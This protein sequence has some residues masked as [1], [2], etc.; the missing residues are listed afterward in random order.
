MT[1]SKLT[2]GTTYTIKV[3]FGESEPATTGG[4]DCSATADYIKLEVWDEAG[5]TLLAYKGNKASNYFADTDKLYLVLGAGA[6]S[7]TANA[8]F[9]DIKA[10]VG[11]TEY[12]I[13]SVTDAPASNLLAISTEDFKKEVNVNE[14]VE[15]S[16]NWNSTDSSVTVPTLTAE[17]N[18]IISASAANG[19]ITINGLAGGSTILTVTH[20]G[21]TALSYKIEVA[22]IDYAATTY[23]GLSLYPANEATSAFEDG[24]FM[25]GGFDEAPVLVSGG[26][27]KIYDSEGNL[28]DTIKF[29][30]ENISIW[31]GISYNVA[32]QLVR[33][34]NKA[35]YF[36]PHPGVLEAGKTYF[37]AIPKGSITGKIGGATFDGLTGD[38]AN[39]QWKFST[40]AA[41]TA[42]ANMIVNNSQSASTQDF[43]TIQGALK[44][45]GTSAGDYTIT[46]EPGVYREL[47]YFGGTANVT[48]KGNSTVSLTDGS[49]SG[50]VMVKFANGQ[51]LNGN[52]NG[53]ANRNLFSINGNANIVL[54]N[55]DF[56]NS[57][58]RGTYAGD[59]QAEVIGHN[60][61][62]KIAAYNCAFRSH[63]DTIRTT[64]KAWFYK[65][66]VEGDVDF[67]WMEV[68]GVVAL[69]EECVIHSVYDE[70]ASSHVTRITAPRMTKD[71]TVGKGL[72]VFNSTITDTEN[73]TTNLG[74]TP[75]TS[76]YY[77]QAAFIGNTI[78]TSGTFTADWEN[79]ATSETVALDAGKFIGWKQYNNKVNGTLVSNATNSTL[80]SDESFIAK[81]YSGRKT[82]LNR[83]LTVDGLL[84]AQDNSVWDISALESEFNA[85]ED[86]SK[87]LLDDE[88]AGKI[89][90]NTYD[91]KDGIANVTATEDS[92]LGITLSSGIGYQNS[93]YGAK[94]A[95]TLT[96]GVTG[97]ALIALYPTYK[98]SG[99]V[100]LY[101]ATDTDHTTALATGTIDN[102]NVDVKI[103]ATGEQNA[104]DYA[105]PV[106]YTGNAGN[107]DLV[108][109]GSN[110]YFWK[111]VV[112][113]PTVNTYDFKDGIANVTAT[114][115]SSLGIT[116]SSGIGYQN[117]SYGAKNAGTLTFGVT[118]SALIALYPTYKASGS[119]KLYAATDTDH[120]T[121]LATGTIDN[122]NVDVK[123]G[124][125]GEQN[126][127]D[128]AVPVIYT[129]NAGNLDLVIE[130][131]NIY[132]WKV[133]VLQF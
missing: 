9:S 117:S 116:L 54:E 43:R 102:K 47:L 90:S 124:A 14:S 75:W 88:S 84:F 3:K 7:S 108:I 65:C 10:Y 104:D 22:V 113:Y 107:L 77:S 78:T 99:S 62:G 87:S 86:T 122:K 89:T 97:S 74:R 21:N 18:T 68:S 95:G 6:G 56:V 40:R 28:V 111:V 120:T 91:F 114:E 129:G 126:A 44:A 80:I 16:Y 128:Y 11:T 85:T 5:T 59:A 4:N 51:S 45:I 70:Y 27:I 38:Y 66:Y 131:S 8:T 69:Y 31:D 110:I 106:I 83:L 100:K 76:G 25:L 92:S 121:A 58:S 82:I 130:G 98:A 64:G 67:L 53:S 2:V 123:I 48:I 103:G 125:T 57:Y 109:E 34:E 101:A 36:T 133:V 24:E 37:V 15:I 19:K 29:A 79:T 23:T 73:Q 17:D 12:K 81:E 33:V 132:F 63:Q 71:A 30:D 119:V 1:D 26:R 39:T 41:K 60:G 20:P 112:S 52:E 55:I 96:F 42:S 13:T 50:E 46:V 35:V 115:D 32:S 49:N 118:G 93:S 127:D 72:V 94:N 105:V 61:K